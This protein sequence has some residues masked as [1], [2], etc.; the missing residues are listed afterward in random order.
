MENQDTKS[1]IAAGLA[2]L[3][4]GAGHCFLGQVKK[5]LLYFCALVALYIWGCYLGSRLPVNP[6]RIDAPEPPPTIRIVSPKNHYFVFSILALAG[7]PTLTVAAAN[8]AAR[9]D[10]PTTITDL[11][12]VITMVVGALNF[13]LIIDAFCWAP[14]Q[15]NE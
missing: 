10:S 12:L 6:E 9:V 4:P 8:K 1:W 11:G 2:W 14:K 5:G 13:L 15:K 7:L 3:I